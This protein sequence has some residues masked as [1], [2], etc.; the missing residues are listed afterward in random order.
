[1]TLSN[2]NLQKRQT[3][4]FNYIN[5]LFDNESYDSEEVTV[6]NSQRVVE[7]DVVIFP[8]NEIS[9]NDDEISIKKEILEN[10]NK[11]TDRE[12]LEKIKQHLKIK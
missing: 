9:E 11:A 6:K 12:N 10:V 7:T 4:C 3:P 1:M 8:I 2:P 5:S